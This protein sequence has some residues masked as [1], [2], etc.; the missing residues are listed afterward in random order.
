MSPKE[1]TENISV[2]IPMNLLAVLDYYCVEADL[3]RSQAVNRA[4]RLY[5]SSKIAKSND[6][7]TREYN[8]LMEESKI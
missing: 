6:F 1:P 3:N 8:R 2:S 4:V 5:L 7:W